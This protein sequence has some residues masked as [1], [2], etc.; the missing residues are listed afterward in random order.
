[1]L[2]ISYLELYYA[3]SYIVRTV[4]ELQLLLTGILG[5]LYYYM[6]GRALLL[7]IQYLMEKLNYNNFFKNIPTPI[8]TSYQL[9]LIE[10]I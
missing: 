2:Y 3:L 9:A 6:I 8:K 7:Y 4:I 1:M 5:A 10:K